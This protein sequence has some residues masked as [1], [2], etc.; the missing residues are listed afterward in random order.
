MKVVAVVYHVEGDSWWAE[1]ADAPGFTAVANSLE[2]LRA[3][4]RSGLEFHFDS[5]ELDVRELLPSVAPV[6][7]PRI[8]S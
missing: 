8:T 5:A 6:S 1:S 4:V 3:L 7:G 2:E